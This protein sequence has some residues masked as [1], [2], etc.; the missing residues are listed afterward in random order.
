MG[1]LKE[2]IKDQDYFAHVITMNFD[3]QGDTHK[4]FAGGLVSCFL[5]IMMCIY[6]FMTFRTWIMKLNNT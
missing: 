4:T 1:K 6:I 3:K 5:N 2:K